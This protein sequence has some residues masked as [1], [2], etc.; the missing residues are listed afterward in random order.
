MDR[1]RNYM[2]L[3]L[4]LI[5]AVFFA[6]VI[7]AKSTA[8]TIYDE[9]KDSIGTIY[10]IDEENKK[11][12]LGSGVA[13]AE[14]LIA[15]NCHVALAGNF[16]I[17]QINGE[18]LLGRLFYYN[19][20]KDLCLIQ[21]AG[22]P[23]KA[24][25]IRPS[26]TV[27]IG[28]DVFAIGNPE[29]HMKTISRG[30]ISNKQMDNGVELLQTD[31]SISHGSSGGGLFDV[32]GN[33]IGITTAFDKNGENIAFAIPTEIISDVIGKGGKANKTISKNEERPLLQ[34]EQVMQHQVE[35]TS[36]V[37]RLGYY[38]KDEV[39]LMKWNGNCFIGVVGR[40][41]NKPS[42]LA[43]W[44]PHKPNGLF[45]FSRVVNAENAIK[46]FNWLNEAKDV[47]Y[48]NS[49]SFIYFDD[50]LFP[51][52]IVTVDKVK[53]PV[54]LFILEEPITENLIDLNYFLG[55]FYHY[56]QSDGMT[57]IKFGLNGF[58]EAYGAYKKLCK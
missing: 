24:V 15:T 20:K 31:A 54:Y 50:D 48:P 28:E 45:I 52:P 29:G 58:T 11:T 25:H 16:L 39:A 5:G 10:S 47:S 33:L 7:H 35:D 49:K 40:Y 44:F 23:L 4:V 34:A 22:S 3:M 21:I 17:I 9:V 55:Q 41:N 14:N 6:P 36:K 13:I 1:L 30:I 18:T 27:N 8:Q 26:K 37:T 53:Q 12:A 57:T 56:T 32:D 43:V 2:F 38:G 46:F 42:S 19:Q 51:L